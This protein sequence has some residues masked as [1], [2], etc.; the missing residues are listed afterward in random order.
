MQVVS[1]HTYKNS[2]DLKGHH[3][4]H[5]QHKPPRECSHLKE[6][7]LMIKKEAHG[8]FRVPLL[9]WE[10]RNFPFDKIGLYYISC[11]SPYILRWIHNKIGIYTF[12]NLRKLGVI[13][14]NKQLQVFS[15]ILHISCNSMRGG[16]GG[17]GTKRA[18]VLSEQMTKVCWTYDGVS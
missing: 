11:H 2:Y 17:G 15:P 12:I 8:K 9:I 6:S 13:R 16:G 14:E 18:F 4:T 3:P 7:I 5:D 1:F 10:A